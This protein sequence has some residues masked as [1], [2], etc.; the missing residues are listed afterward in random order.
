MTDL[1]PRSDRR[2]PLGTTYRGSGDLEIAVAAVV[3][4]CETTGMTCQRQELEDCVV[5]IDGIQRTAWHRV[6]FKSLPQRCEWRLSRD[7]DELWIYSDFGWL[8]WFQGL[9]TGLAVLLVLCFAGVVALGLDRSGFDRADVLE[10]EVLLA[11]V[12]L[13]HQLA[14]VKVRKAEDSSSQPATA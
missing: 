2:R 3:A 9:L 11:S 6:L 10:N 8:R 12:V 14:F 5:Q 7:R 4:A 1:N 13:I